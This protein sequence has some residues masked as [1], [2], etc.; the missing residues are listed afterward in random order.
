MRAQMSVSLEE[1]VPNFMISRT[2][3]IR[4]MPSPISRFLRLAELRMHVHMSGSLGEN[5]PIIMTPDAKTE[6]LVKL[7]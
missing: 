3:I 7:S 6:I 1:N 4:G 2:K 5:V